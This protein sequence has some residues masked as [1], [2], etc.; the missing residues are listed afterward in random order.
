VN[1]KKANLYVVSV[2]CAV[3]LAIV[4]AL[5][6]VANAFSTML[7]SYLGTVGGSSQSISFDTDYE[8]DDDLL[9]AQKATAVQ[10]VED[11]TVLMKNNGGALPLSNTSSVTLFSKSATSWSGGSS[12][13]SDQSHNDI[14]FKT[15]LEEKGVRV[16]SAVWD[17][18]SSD[19][20]TAN[21][22]AGAVGSGV[23]GYSINE[24]DWDTVSEEVGGSF[25][26][27]QDAAIVVIA[28]GNGEGNDVPMD[29][30]SRG[31]QP[32]EIYME[33][34]EAE[35]SL[36]RGI[37]AAGFQKTI[38]VI[39]AAVQMQLDFL[40]DAE[41]GVDACLSLSGTG[42][43]GLLGL[44][45]ILVGDANPSGHLV[46]TYVYDNWSAPATQNL[47]DM[48]YTNANGS[49]VDGANYTFLAYSEGIYVGYRY[50]E[51]RY[52]DA[53]LGRTNVGDYNYSKT[54]ARPFGFGMSYTD[55]QWSN[56]SMEDVDDTITVKV[57]V[58]N[59]GNVAGKDA[60]G[61]YFQSEYT[62]KDVEDR[63]EKSAV[64]L[65]GFD[66]TQSIEPGQSEEI[67]ITFDKKNIMKSYSIKDNGYIFEAGSYYITAAQDAH[68]AINNILLAK[69]PSSAGKLQ[70]AGG[71][72]PDADATMVSNISVTE[73]ELLTTD[74][75]TGY[76]VENRFGYAD[77]TAYGESEAMAH[78][79]RSN[80]TMMDNNGLDYSTGTADELSAS[81][82]GGP[83]KTR[84]IPNGLK[85]DIDT[86]G[87]NYSGRP[88]S[89]RNDATAVIA[90]DAGLKLADLVNVE[91]G[92]PQWLTLVQQL[93]VSE[94]HGLFNQ[95]GWVTQ[96]IDTIEMPGSSCHDGPTGLGNYLNDWYSYSWP[97]EV[98]LA[99][100]W[101]TDLAEKMGELIGEDGLRTGVAGWY[102]P[103]MNMHRTPFG[104]RASEYYSEDGLMAGKMGAA[105][106]RGAQSKGMY[107]FIK[108][109]GVND[110]E[111]NRDHITMWLDE[112]TLREIYLKPFEISVKE[113]EALGAMDSKT[114]L[115]H[116]FT[117]G[118]YTL[119][120]E[121]FRNEWGFKG[122]VIT[123]YTSQS[124]EM[125]EQCLSAGTDLML[126]S[127]ALKLPET[128]S[129]YI[130]N[131]LQDSAIHTA[132][133]VSRS[134]LM[135]N[136]VAGTSYQSGTPVY[137]P[138][139]IVVDV[140]FGLTIIAAEAI[141]IRSYL[142]SKKEVR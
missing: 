48:R 128:K 56:Y 55:F 70:S 42:S 65:A 134:A 40:D 46:D 23:A 77:P 123:D 18:Y 66:K 27:Y 100:T 109:I 126:T 38:V 52:E 22:A 57:T 24:P 103:A 142:K 125:T 28:R 124:A 17:Y 59:T 80:W 54:V 12:S 53:V 115:G 107:V 60:V 37:K 45:N 47:G 49:Y 127:A 41:Y 95:A 73:T 121:V 76:T 119:I 61:V 139:L 20:V 106:T 131:A 35:R 6:L 130:R 68:Q 11:G 89:E 132:Y 93:K 13:G 51:T 78:L 118:D 90:E 88:D 69:E 82:Y 110:Q 111:I 14:N 67:T 64:V 71:G 116:R 26:G 19:K 31:G 29:M 98:L 7:I 122:S 30:E 33:L 113:G 58:T 141:V 83:I 97:S 137:V 136:L 112:Q 25:S 3:I 79:T 140:V 117:K 21:T 133:M 50:Y 87:W 101:E 8:T 75:A 84:Q 102:A 92:D 85:D 63:I 43:N 39:N 114:R 104:G 72:T 99:S 105:T 108:H 44:V 138:I 74:S 91:Y 86:L 129:D 15:A 34:N 1:I 62:D 120:T 9:A 2:F 32:G 94:I 10:I 4:I 135:N 5:N 81:S 96:K 36:L 16:N